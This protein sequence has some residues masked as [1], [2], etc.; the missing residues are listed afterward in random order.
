MKLDQWIFSFMSKRGLLEPDGRALFAYKTSLEEFETLRQVLQETP[1]GS[2]TNPGYPQAWLLFAAEWWK[3]DYPG[4]AWRW[5]PLCEAAG[6]PGLTHEKT[7]RLVIEGSR[8]WRLQTAMAL[9]RNCPSEHSYPFPQ[10]IQDTRIVCGVP[11]RVN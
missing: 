2:I 8:L 1:P 11:S 3:R 5:G 4:G 6:L 9:L 7:R 10:T